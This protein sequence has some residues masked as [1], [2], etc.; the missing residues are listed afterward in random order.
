MIGEIDIGVAAF[1]VPCEKDL[2]LYHKNKHEKLEKAGHIHIRSEFIPIPEPPHPIPREVEHFEIQHALPTWEKG[3]LKLHVVAAHISHDTEPG[4]ADK[5]DPFVHLQV[6]SFQDWRSEVCIN[7]D[8]NPKWEHQHMEIDVKHLKQELTIEVRDK[9]ILGSEPI[10]T[11][12]VSISFF[13]RPE[14]VFDDWIELH[15]RGHHE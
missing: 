10:G 2:E 8:R 4:R 14:G 11:A 13:A 6:G 1:A 3:H 12:V 15:F 7:G 5:M 9:D